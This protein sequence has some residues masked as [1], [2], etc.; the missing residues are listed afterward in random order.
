MKEKAL[1]KIQ[2]KS[3]RPKTKLLKTQPKTPQ[4]S[5]E[6]ALDFI[7]SYQKMLADLDEP[8]QSISLRIPGNLLRA[9]KIK[10][11]SENKKYQSMIIEMI[12]SDLKRS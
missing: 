9:L 4:I 12:R 5:P 6:E 7:D 8:T 11:K 1:K 10:A 2:K 3:N